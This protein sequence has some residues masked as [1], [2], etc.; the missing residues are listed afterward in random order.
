MKPNV[1]PTAARAALVALL[2]AATAAT[3]FAQT[4][5]TFTV[6]GPVAIGEAGAQDAVAADFDKDGD[7][8]LI[9]TTAGTPAM[10]AP[11]PQKVNFLINNGSGE[12]AK[13]SALSVPGAARVAVADFNGDGRSDIAVTVAP[14]GQC[15]MAPGVAVFL[16]SAGGG[17][18]QNGPCLSAGSSPL[19]IQAADFNGDSIAD[20]AVAN[21]DGSGIRVFRGDG[22]GGFQQPGLLL[23][24]SSIGVRDMATP[25]DINGD[26][27]LDIVV[28]Y[29]AGFKAFLGRGD[30]TFTTGGNTTPGG[31]TLAIA[32]GDV[33][34]DAIPDL[35]EL[36]SAAYRID[37]GNGVGIGNGSFLVGGNTSIGP[38]MQDLALVDMDSDGDLDIVIAGG[39]AG[40]G[41]RLFLNNGS[42]TFSNSPIPVSSPN[43][44][45]A[46]GGDFNA[47]GS[48]DVAIV[49][50][51]RN[52]VFIVLQQD[53]ISPTVDITTPADGSTVRENVTIRATA[54]DNVGVTRVDFFANDVLIGSSTSGPEF[55]VSWNASALAG[56]FTIRA[57]AF[58][59]IGHFADD[60]VSVNV[61]DIAKPSAPGNLTAR[62]LLNFHL[63]LLDWTASTD[64]VGVD[65]YRVYEL[66]R[67]NKNL[68]TWELVRDGV[69]GT[70]ALVIIQGRRGQ[71][72]TF[73]VTAVDAAGNESDRSVVEVSRDDRDRDRNDDDRDRDDDDDDRGRD[74]DENGRR[75]RN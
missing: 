42:G 35:A 13:Q 45:R 50:A 69:D 75:D 59:A 53:R 57:R 17:L 52:E 25:V 26:F 62:S 1:S 33:T 14:G 67:R 41:T 40:V 38:G 36:S 11:P 39:A 9:V 71:A 32:V 63:V 66:V 5:P 29:N 74:D 18:S 65:H 24:D 19:A 16:G 48:S 43:P 15:F 51:G 34:G 20:I 47:D 44:V 55:S 60:S 72:H 27:N 37:R 64:N 3:T 73:A 56:P 58:D 22:V 2:V 70:A 31:Q 30:G 49:D 12:L 68:S 46:V 21:S 7:L 4:A 10:G 6:R 54:A 61:L 28:G 23:N 8:D